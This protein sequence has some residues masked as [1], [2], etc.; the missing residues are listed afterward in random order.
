MNLR[1]YLTLLVFALLAGPAPAQLLS[2]AGKDKNKDGGGAPPNNGQGPF[3]VGPWYNYWP[4][5]AHFQVPAVPQYP[6]WGAPMT[7]PVAPPAPYQATPITNLPNQGMPYGNGAQ[8]M[9]LPPAAGQY[10]GMAMPGMGMPGMGMPGM[11]MPGMGM[12]GMMPYPSAPGYPQ[13]AQP[14]APRGPA[15][16]QYPNWQGR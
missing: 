7:L 15:V 10:P 3:S 9:T 2:F 8:G 12:P 1:I 6:F 11:G 14:Q 13:A 16:M 4:L 5:E